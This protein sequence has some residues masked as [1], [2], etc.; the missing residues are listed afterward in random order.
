MPSNRTSPFAPHPKPP[1]NL[2]ILRVLSPR[3]GVRVS[4]ICLGGGSIGDRWIDNG[5][6]DNGV[7]NKEQ[8]FKLLDAFFA[9]GGNFI[10]T[11]NHYHEET[12]EEY[13]GE[14]MESRGI[15]D[16]VV[17]AT[18]YGSCFKTIDPNIEQTAN[19][20]GGH[21]KSLQLSLKHS[22]RKLRTDYID[23]LYLHWWDF[24]ISIEEVMDGLHNLVVSGKVLYLGVCN[25][26]AWI[27]AQANQYAKLTGKTPFIIY[28]GRWG[29]LDR[30]FERDIIPMARAHGMALA[31]FS[32]LG[33][34]RLRT[35][36][37]EERREK[38]GEKGRSLLTFKPDWK[39]T[40]EE[41]KLSRALEKVA[42]EIGAK[43]ITAVA[44]AY[45]MQK[46]PYVFPIIG[47]KKIE[48]LEQ[49]IESLDIKLTP[50][51]IE[52]LESEAPPFD[53]GMLNDG[54]KPN[55]LLSAGAYYQRMPYPQ[56]L[57]P[58]SS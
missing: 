29:L 35:D 41:V 39:R 49:N 45:V 16:Q 42:K 34:G 23:I 55:F 7:L 14:W 43:S 27:V 10:D 12:S 24:D 53:P 8:C 38:S 5:V 46:T 20:T 31:P 30:S 2:G 47:G 1:T 18:K 32:V 13:I 37:E 4:P 26:P 51:H 48:Y 28:Q 9:K 3:A 52:Y 33:A 56:A 6:L 17:L 21:I 44:I 40:P 57:G 19:Y 22:L 11:A 58:A 15:R 25:T 36:E 54:D 50:E